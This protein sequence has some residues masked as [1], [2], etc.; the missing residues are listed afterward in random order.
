MFLTAIFS[1][2]PMIEWTRMLV[3]TR[4]AAVLKTAIGKVAPTATIE[5]VRPTEWVVERVKNLGGHQG[6]RKPIQFGRT[7]Q[8]KGDGGQR[9]IPPAVH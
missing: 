4:D 8:K 2:E 6:V 1:P 3:A 9:L 5:G 7:I